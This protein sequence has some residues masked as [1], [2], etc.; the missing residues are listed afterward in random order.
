M[1]HF[2]LEVVVKVYHG[3]LKIWTSQTVERERH[4]KGERKVISMINTN[5]LQNDKTVRRLAFSE[6][7]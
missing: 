7:W 2:I 3:L 6:N 4:G 1:L 5:I